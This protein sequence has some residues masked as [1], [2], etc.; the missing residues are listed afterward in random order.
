ME[1]GNVLI[2]GIGVCL[3]TIASILVVFQVNPQN[4][5]IKDL[6]NEEPE[7]NESTFSYPDTTFKEQPTANG[8]TEVSKELIPL[9]AGN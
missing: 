4:I 5:V 9:E 3:L 8:K 7:E 2:A 6:F 1:T